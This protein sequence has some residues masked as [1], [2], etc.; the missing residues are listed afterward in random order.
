VICRG[1]TRLICC[2]G[3]PHCLCCVVHWHV[4]WTADSR[5]HL[6]PA[7]SNLGSNASVFPTISLSCYDSE[8]GGSKFWRWLR[9][10]IVTKMGASCVDTKTALKVCSSNDVLWAC[11]IQ[12]YTVYVQLKLLG[13]RNFMINWTRILWARYMTEYKHINDFS[14][15]TWRNYMSRKT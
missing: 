9:K 7:D 15:E 4:Y 3:T 1:F 14:G 13:W 6:S 8:P 11:S 10:Y 5:N 2:S 12:C